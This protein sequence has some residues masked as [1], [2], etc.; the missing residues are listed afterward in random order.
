MMVVKMVKMDKSIT[1]MALSTISISLHFGEHHFL[2]SGMM[3]VEN[4]ALLLDS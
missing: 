2:G 4:A 1:I 3:L